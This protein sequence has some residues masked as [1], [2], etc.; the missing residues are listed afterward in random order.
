MSRTIVVITFAVALSLAASAADA[1]VPVRLGGHLALGFPVGDFKDKTD[2]TGVGLDGYAAFYVPRVPLQVG[3]SLGF[4]S[5]GSVTSLH[6]IV[7]PFAF[8]ITTRNN[9]F[10]GHAFLRLQPSRA[11]FQPYMDW[12]VGFKRF[13]TTSELGFGGDAAAAV[14]QTDDWTF[15][16]GVGLGTMFEVYDS[17]TDGGLNFAISVDIGA[18]YLIGGK[19]EY[20]KIDSVRIVDDV[21]VYDVTSSRTDMVTARIGASVLF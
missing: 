4:M 16:Y 17:T 14:T 5:Q 20:V 8:A 2:Q 15:S 9:I 7:Y 12:L 3:A 1:R 6:Q 18:R 13:F 19:A 21:A 11:D 10:S